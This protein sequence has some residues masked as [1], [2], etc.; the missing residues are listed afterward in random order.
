MLLLDDEELMAKL[1][2]DA[3][4]LARAEPVGVPTAFR[5]TVDGE[6]VTDSAEVASLLDAAQLNESQRNAVTSALAQR[7][8][9]IQGPPGTGKTHCSVQLLKMFVANQRELS[10][11]QGVA[12]EHTVLATAN[13]NTAADNLLEGLLAEGVKAVRAGPRDKVRPTLQAASMQA[14]MEHHPARKVEKQLEEIVAQLVANFRS[15]D[16]MSRAMGLN[17]ATAAMLNKPKSRRELK[18][19]LHRART[20]L[21]ELRKQIKEDIYSSTE[22]V[23][24]TCIAAG[25]LV[26][27]GLFKVVLIDEASQSTVPTCLVPISKGCRQL[28]LVGDSNQLPPTVKTDRAMQGGLNRSLFERLQDMG[29]SSIMLNTQYRMHPTIAAFSSEHFYRGELRSADNVASLVPPAGFDWPIRGGLSVPVAFVEAV[30]DSG[31]DISL[32]GASR[33][34]YKEAEAVVGALRDLLM[35]GDVAATD[36]GIVTPYKGQVELFG[37]MLATEP[38]FE[39]VEVNSVDGYQGREKELV[40][41]S[42]V[43][44]NPERRVGF[45]ADWRRLNVAITRAKRGL[46]MFGDPETLRGDEIWANLLDHFAALAVESNGA[47]PNKL[48][49]GIFENVISPELDQLQR[50]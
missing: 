25:E 6:L 11:Q 35:A 38:M 27:T 50:A 37:K 33:S 48:S 20:Q 49:S 24:A 32:D 34:N 31:E 23:V 19:K 36:I 1:R 41:F 44:S 29:I 2:V 10:A 16:E 39:G 43:R 13:S 26:D 21:E 4:K 14:K 28:V 18:D 22:V 12:G 5:R 3:S 15:A 17:A 40:M 30:S 46:L 7:L 45:L 47:G 9:L 8:T 42:A